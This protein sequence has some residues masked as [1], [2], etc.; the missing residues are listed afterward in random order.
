MMIL[1]SLLSVQVDAAQNPK[2]V[3]ET[4]LG[5]IT[6]ELYPDKAPGTVKNFLAYVDEKFYAGTIF[7]RVISSF[8]IQGGGFTADMKEKA[9]HNPI[10]NEADNGLKNDRGT[11]AM[12]RT[13]DPNSATSQFFINTKGNTFLNF[14]SKSPDGYGYC[15]FGKVIKGLDVVDTI[16]KTPTTTKGFYQDVPATPVVIKK[17]YRLKEDAGAAE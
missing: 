7:H 8:M 16:E 17:A 9:T 6:L 11:V 3:L 1:F 5:N 14:R 4:S 15:V 13:P 2:V 10:R 12:A